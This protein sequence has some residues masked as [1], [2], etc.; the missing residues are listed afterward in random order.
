MSKSKADY[1]SEA[2]QI[3]LTGLRVYLNEIT[4]IK[5]GPYKSPIEKADRQDLLGRM[6]GE[7]EHVFASKLPRICR[8]YVHELKEIRNMDAHDEHLTLDH[9]RRYVDTLSLFLEAIK[10]PEETNAKKL[11]EKIQEQIQSQKN[12][13]ISPFL[14]TLY[15]IQC[16]S[17]KGFVSIPP[18]KG[19]IF[20]GVNEK[21]AEIL[22]KIREKKMGQANLDRNVFYPA[23]KGYQGI[24]YENAEKA[25][26]EAVSGGGHILIVS[27]VYGLVRATETI[28]RYDANFHYEDWNQQGKSILHDALVEYLQHFKLK[29][30]RLLFTENTS[31]SKVEKSLGSRV[32]FLD[33]ALSFSFPVSSTD[34]FVHLKNTGIVLKDLLL[35]GKGDLEDPQALQTI[36]SLMNSHSL[37]IID[38]LKV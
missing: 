10:S 23:F 32:N 22:R 16:S 37:K 35:G 7:W 33:S 19:D 31:Y 9:V 30:L 17:K 34:K 20:E 25:L 36:Q 13:L 11:M 27:G 14:D 18:L 2:H 4:E 8:T 28:N 24:T 6:I 29:H 15:V 21:T 26:Q 1:F 3:L 5:N 38:L 12:C